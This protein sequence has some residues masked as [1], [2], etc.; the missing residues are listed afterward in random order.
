MASLA[1]WPLPGWSQAAAPQAASPASAAA[2]ASA[3]EPLSLRSTPRLPDRAAAGAAAP[4]GPVSLRAERLLVR[5]DIDARAEGQV[6][7][8][9]APTVIRAQRLHYDQASDT[10][11]ASGQV[12]VEHGGVRYRGAELQ[13]QLQR[14][15][16]WFLA[17][18]FEFLTLGA[19]GRAERIDLL[20][21]SRSRA[22]RAIYTSCPRDDGAE[23]DWL[24]RTE[25][26]RLDLAANE[27]IAEG[28]VLQF[29]GVPILALPVVSF[30]LTDDR[31]SG[32]LPPTL[33]P[34]DS[35]NGFTLSVPYYWNIA[36]NRDATFTPTVYLRRGLSLTSEFRWLEPRHGGRISLH[37][38]PHDRVAGS[39]RHAWAIEQQTAAPG[40]LQLSL[41]AQ[42]VSDDS[43]W[44]DFPQHVPGT[45]PRLLSQ[46]LRAERSFSTRFGELNA[47]ARVQQ[48]QVLQTGEDGDLIVSPYQRS[49][50]LGLRLAP[51]PGQLPF[52]LRAGLETEVNRFTLP[53]VSRL[54][55]EAA[56]LPT[57]WRW[58]GLGQIS[59]PI[60]RPAWWLT[61]KL[62]FNA[63]A[64]DLDQAGLPRQ[65]AQ[66]FIPT[67]SLDGGL[68]A[69]RRS[70]WFGR[71]QRQTLEPRLLYVNTPYRDQSQLPLFDT[72]ERD[73]NAVS[74][75]AEN[76]FSGIDRVPD[77]HQLTAGVTTRM[78]DAQ[79]GVETFRLGLAQRFRFRD[80]RVVVEGE[81]QTQRVSDMLIEGSTA[82]FNPW[83]L[84]AALQYNPDSSR[85]VRSI[86]GARWTPG[87]MRTLSLGYRLARGLSEQAEFAWQWPVYRGTAQPVGASR[88]CGGTVYAVG[89][90]NY[91]MRDSRL[92]D[93]IVGLEYDS[94][95]W[96]ARIV[97]E[98]LSTGRAE[99]RTQ[100]AL[101]LELVGLSRL[102]SNPL[103][104]LKDN[105]PGYQLLREPRGATSAPF[106]AP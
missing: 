83:R 97:A 98:R 66:R 93:A 21:S 54:A 80:Q 63:A 99:A 65:R 14:F 34:V 90:M 53:H 81:P 92:T 106:A 11:S 61:P 77:A 2:S 32:W 43:Y 50:Q 12:E 6:E 8:R 45:S 1:F 44:K 49:P 42:R 70:T 5:P 10:A 24:L 101:Q 102:G 82:V 62:A 94:A 23:P 48:W 91:S 18:E 41:Q 58:H 64:Y 40:G 79:T 89:R 57:G 52:G 7:L 78:V 96:I 71:P 36:P 28:A 47:Y 46:D 69:E 31:K 25:R 37:A 104:V 22:Q 55:A 60:V 85:V 30:P 74:I 68:V 87:P 73:F 103:Q 15:E 33:V 13:L 9:R 38:L 3:A 75:Y 76:A 88:G 56:A 20:D 16:G 59:R 105:I 100:L 51:Q 67:L 26:V 95:C 19:G 72:A 27:G 29:L 84:D 86:L 17:P 35:R 39:S 4:A